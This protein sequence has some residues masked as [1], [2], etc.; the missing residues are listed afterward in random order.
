ML[1]ALG[2]M[3]A[4][5]FLAFYWSAPESLVASLWPIGRSSDALSDTNVS[6]RLADADAVRGGNALTTR[7]EGV[8]GGLPPRPEDSAFGAAGAALRPI[9]TVAH[10]VSA[11]LEPTLPWIAA[12]WMLGVWLV[13]LRLACGGVW[14]WRTARDGAISEPAEILQACARVADA[15]GFTHAVRVAQSAWVETPV[16]LGWVR[17]IILL[18][19]SALIGLTPQQLEM[20]IAHELAHVA[21]YDHILNLF[22]VVVETILFY[23]PAV[24]WLSRRIRDEREL[25]CD[26]RAMALY[27]D[28]FAYASALAFLETQRSSAPLL[29]L[30][31]TGG[32]LLLRMRRLLIAPERE[33]RS[34]R[35]VGGILLL[36][37]LI[38]LFGMVTVG[39]A[40]QVLARP[41][42]SPSHVSTTA[43]AWT[44]ARFPQE[45]V[46]AICVR[47]SGTESFFNWRE[48]NPASGTLLFPPE[49]EIALK[50]NPEQVQGLAFLEELHPN[51]LT[52]LLAGVFFEYRAGNKPPEVAY[53]DCLQTAD[54]AR[55]PLYDEDM[56]YVASL[57]GLRELYLDHT[58]VGDAGIAELSNLQSLE[59]LSLVDTEI[60]DTALAYV[61]QLPHLRTLNLTQTAVTD[62]GLAYLAA[63]ESL[64][65]LTLD[66]T[67]VTDEGVAYLNEL[68]GLERL[69]LN[70]TATTDATLTLFAQHP[71]LFTLRAWDTDTSELTRW[72]TA[73]GTGQLKYGFAPPKVGILLSDFNARTG[74]HWMQY[75]YTYRHAIGLAQLLVDLGFDIYAIVEPGTE[76]A[77][78]LP[79]VLEWLGLED[80]LIDGTDPE[81]LAELDVVF[82]AFDADVL[83]GVQSALTQAVKQGTGFFNFCLFGVVYP[84][85]GAALEEV[86]GI[87]GPDYACHFDY[88]DCDVV[89][90]HPLLG[91]LQPGDI[92][93]AKWLNGFTGELR[94]TP[95]LMTQVHNK[96]FCPLYVY[97]LG[98]GRVVNMQWQQITV[99]NGGIDAVALYGRCVNYAAG[100]P[101]DATW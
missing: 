38:G 94:G 69:S 56:V 84:G 101:V 40:Q 83:D 54:R 82:S 61:A 89:A 31:A 50:L 26:D 21:R 60:S 90:S 45:G 91:D 41:A 30:A 19:P 37:T 28:R 63:S 55:M 16:L 65:D 2:M 5:P 52:G 93:T 78:R 32:S 57:S 36:L 95:L 10:H 75:E 77:G 100:A 62:T 4:A 99:T 29:G 97:D 48:T 67:S 3:A 1:V 76:D 58:Y 6:N 9:G 66:R 15:M 11:M 33:V 24:W 72:E 35:L 51:A 34:G 98:R 64:Q 39:A 68:D 87:N 81:A 53:A 12:L 80:R 7:Q 46:G 59:V 42:S 47:E 73:R 71:S 85:S 25:C 18:P 49:T 86:L 88:V 14:V 20:V 70:F 96:P 23:H 13:A 44:E 27:D 79:E 43:V 22:Q 74:E 8:E 17:P 92:F